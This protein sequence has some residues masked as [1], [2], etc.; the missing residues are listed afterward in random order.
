MA[1]PPTSLRHERLFTEVT[2][3]I[4]DYLIKCADRG[5]KVFTGVGLGWCT[6]FTWSNILQ[7]SSNLFNPQVCKN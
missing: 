2:A 6:L 7:K 5:S 1:R 3:L 4:R